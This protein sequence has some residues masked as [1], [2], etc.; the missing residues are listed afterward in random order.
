METTEKVYIRALCSICNNKSKELCNITNTFD[1]KVK[2]VFYDRA[3]RDKKK[4]DKDIY[5][6]ANKKRPVMKG[7]V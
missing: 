7:L 5:V 2:C 1:N 3:V 4:V 6:I